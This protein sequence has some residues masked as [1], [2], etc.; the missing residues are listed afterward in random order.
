MDN[1]LTGSSLADFMA[2][3]NRDESES[4]SDDFGENDRYKQYGI[5]NAV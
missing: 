4:S 2:S 5:R 3:T 1:R